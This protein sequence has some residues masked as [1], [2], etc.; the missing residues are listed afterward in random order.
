MAEKE[1]W[2]PGTATLELVDMGINLLKI[3]NLL[4]TTIDQIIN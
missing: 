3:Y 2:I 4:L 1:N